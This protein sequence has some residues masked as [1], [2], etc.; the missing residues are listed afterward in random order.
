MK[1]GF[2]LIE[3]LI[4]VAIIG[5]LAAIA[6]PNF[7]M[8]QIRAKV[9]NTRAEQQ[10]LGT[11]LEAYRVDNSAYARDQPY[12]QWEHGV[13]ATLISVKAL[14][15]LTTPVSFIKSVPQNPFGNKVD[16]ENDLW[17]YFRYYSEYWKGFT[18]MTR[19]ATPRI[20]SL[21]SCGPNAVTNF[22]EYL[23]YGE[24][25]V[26]SINIWGFRGCIY[27]PTNGVVS[28]GD[29]VRIGP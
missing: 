12:W 25:V 26:N 21:T 1:K 28:D 9:A 18:S 24:A 14:S 6:I 27:D 3:L 8:A 16:Q 20:W 15:A 17:A 13:P 2:T 5:I 10:T 22:G 29:I 7:L 11:A 23:I 19:P 4:V